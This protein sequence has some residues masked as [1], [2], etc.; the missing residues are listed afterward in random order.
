MS[1]LLHSATILIQKPL[2]YTAMMQQNDQNLN[3][4]NR[5]LNCGYIIN[6][7]TKV[8]RYEKILIQHLKYHTF[9]PFYIQLSKSTAYNLNE[10]YCQ[11]KCDAQPTYSPHPG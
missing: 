3:L 10:R 7:K 5:F 9:G 6:L 2:D 8:N 11:F 1:G 4:K